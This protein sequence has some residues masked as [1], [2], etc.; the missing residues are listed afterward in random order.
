MEPFL[1]KSLGRDQTLTTS[2]VG[3]AGRRLLMER[4]T[5]I[6]TENPQFGEIDYFPA[7]LTSN[8]QAMQLKFQ[9]T[10]SPGTQVLAA[11]TWSHALSYGSTDPEWPLHYVNSDFDIRHNLQT[12]IAWSEPHLAGDWFRRFVLSGWRV[13]G[14]LTLRSAFPVTVLGTIATDPATG[15]RY[16]SGVDQIRGRPLYLFGSEYP[17]GRMF[18]G[19]PTA[20]DPT[21]RVHLYHGAA[22]YRRGWSHESGSAEQHCQPSACSS[23]ARAFRTGWIQHRGQ[24]RRIDVQR[25]A[26]RLVDTC[27]STGHHRGGLYGPV[28]DVE[29][30]NKRETARARSAYVLRSMPVGDPQHYPAPDR[31]LRC[32][33]HHSFDARL[34]GSSGRCVRWMAGTNDLFANARSF[35]FAGLRGRIGP[36]IAGSGDSSYKSFPS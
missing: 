13:D 25:T 15:N 19:G 4:R 21:A 1:E 22:I 6:T 27:R 28:R 7:G 33:W 29:L 32:N 18:N 26:A 16:Y 2:W 23:P 9:R 8:Y 3:A 11:Y 17:G 10:V 30:C 5:N 20:A 12:A 14:R 36:V 34:A 31:A 24:G 35:C